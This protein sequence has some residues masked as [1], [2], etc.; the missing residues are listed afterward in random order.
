MAEREIANPERDARSP[1]GGWTGFYLQYWMPGRHTMDMQL[2]WVDGKLT[3]QGSD[4]VGPYTID[5]DYETDTGKCSCVR[6]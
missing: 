4:R 5:G 6:G 1:N 3:G 2:M